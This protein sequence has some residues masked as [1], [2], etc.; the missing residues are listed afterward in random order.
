MTDK[1][2]RVLASAGLALGGV[3]G[4]AGTFA[5]SAGL[6]GLAWGIDGMCLVVASALLA[7][8]YFRKGQDF[9]ASGYVVFAVG[10]GQ[11][12]S[13]AAMD[14]A[15]SVPSFGAGVSLWAAALVLISGPRVFPSL[16]RVLGL[17]TSAL[18]AVT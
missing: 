12:L 6:R 15:A 4:I 2:L 13:G 7:V 1:Y 9:V 18:F 10:E 5:T 3:L 8:Y 17:V 14:L 11:I 16:V